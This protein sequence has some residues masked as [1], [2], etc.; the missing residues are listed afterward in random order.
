MDFSTYQ[1]GARTTAVYPG[2]GEGQWTYPAL[3]L[4]GET[5]EVCEK[6]KKAIRDDG[7]KVN[8]E[9][10]AAISKE[11]GDV[12]WYVASVAVDLGSSL[13]EV[14]ERNV[15]KLADRDARGVIHGSGDDR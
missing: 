6:L 9:R 7:G 4:A 15:A 2:C 14:A 5:G 13:E 8:A 3:G 1:R 11:L 12:L 10:L